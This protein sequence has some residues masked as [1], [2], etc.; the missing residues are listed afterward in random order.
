M[1]KYAVGGGEGPKDAG[2]E[3]GA[4]LGLAVELFVSVD[5]SVETA[6]F[7]VLHAV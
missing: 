7:V 3:D 1:G 2:V 6:V 5:A 4:L